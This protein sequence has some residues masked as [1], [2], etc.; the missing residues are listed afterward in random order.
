[1]DNEKI[2]IVMNKLNDIKSASLDYS[3]ETIDKQIELYCDTMEDSYKKYIKDL[4]NKENNIKD[5][6]STI[7]DFQDKLKQDISIGSAVISAFNLT[8]SGQIY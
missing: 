5:V 1:M 8:M 7:E 4:V 3:A 2:D 6:S